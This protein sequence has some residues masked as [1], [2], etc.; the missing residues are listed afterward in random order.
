MTPDPTFF[1]QVF[2]ELLKAVFTAVF[3]LIVLFVVGQRIIFIWDQR[4]KYQELDNATYIQFQELQGEFYEITKVWRAFYRRTHNQKYKALDFNENTQVE[5]FK[6]ASAAESKVDV[7]INKLVAE[8]CLCKDDPK[9]LGL[10]RLNL[11]GF[12][13]GSVIGLRPIVVGHVHCVLVVGGFELCWWNAADLMVDAT[14]VEPVDV[15]EQG[16]LHALQSMPGLPSSNSSLLSSP[17][18]VSAKALS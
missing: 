10:Y 15:A 3:T 2:L 18:V 13:G 6:R 1:E 7:M 12:I 9:T 17:M 4:K 8:R 14:G 5:L 11:P 16:E